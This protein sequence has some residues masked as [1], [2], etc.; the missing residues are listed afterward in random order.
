MRRIVATGGDGSQ[1]KHYPG[2]IN[3]PSK[4]CW[5]TPRDISTVLYGGFGGPPIPLLFTSTVRAVRDVRVL[6]NAAGAGPIPIGRAPA[7]TGIRK[8]DKMATMLANSLRAD[9]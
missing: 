8:G 5:T 4:F 7:S 6:A 9:R 3:C 2:K 1:G